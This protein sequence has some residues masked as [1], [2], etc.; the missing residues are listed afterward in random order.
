ME[1]A[2]YTLQDHISIFDT[3]WRYTVTNLPKPETC[4]QARLIK[5]LTLVCSSSAQ[6]LYLRWTPFVPNRAT[7]EHAL[8]HLILVSIADFRPLYESQDP[9]SPSNHKQTIEYLVKFLS[10]G[11][12]INGVRYSFFGHS[13]SQ[14]KSRSCYFLAGS[15]KEVGNI[16]EALGDFGKIKTAA[17]KAK[18]IGLLFSTAN[19]VCEVSDARYQDIDDIERDG[20]IFTDGCGLASKDFVAFFASKKPI[21]YRDRRYHPS[22]L[23]IRYKGYKG[24]VTI[25]PQMPKGIWL[26]FRKSMKKFSGTSDLSFAVVEHSKVYH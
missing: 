23:Q 26:K 12:V 4:H 10:T 2:K 25:E 11:I 8:D 21:I 16:V 1:R 15:K 17:K 19:F 22:V 3:E 9:S 6:G 20:F 14:L 18:R 24:V 7:Q 13:N 5:A